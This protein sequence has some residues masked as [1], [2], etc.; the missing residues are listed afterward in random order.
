MDIQ[1]IHLEVAQA[2][3]TFALVE[4]YPTNDGSVFVK[5][6]LQTSVG[7]AY[8]ATIYFPNYPNQMPKVFIAKPAVQTG[9]G[10]QYTDGRICYLHHNMWNP[11]RHDLTFV[12]GRTAK[13]LNKYEVWRVT[14]KWPGAEIKH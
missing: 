1:R 14:G 12:L 5:A 13:W 8:V 3:R 10:H 4:A 7:N 2:T 6:G 11:G 9:T